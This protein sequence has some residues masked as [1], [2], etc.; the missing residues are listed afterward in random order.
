V[1]VNWS[2]EAPPKGICWDKI[3]TNDL[4]LD[5]APRGVTAKQAAA[6]YGLSVSGF[7]KARREGAIPEPT[8]PGRR[9]DLHLLQK[10]MNLASGIS[11]S[12]GSVSPLEQW[13]ANRARS[14]AGH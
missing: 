3:I 13:R 8:L 4:S 6:L 1:I 14:T 7:Y 5:L 11:T 2:S 12:E 10:A 9:Y